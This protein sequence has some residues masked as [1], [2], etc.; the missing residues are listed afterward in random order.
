M[1]SAGI[2]CAG[3]ICGLIV[4]YGWAAV[5]P[6]TEHKGVDP[7]LLAN[8]PAASVSAQVGLEGYQL[9]LRRITIS[10]GGQ[11]ARHSHAKS[12]GV[13]YI[14]SGSWVEGRPGRETHYSAG[15][16]FAEDIN[17][18]HWFY[19]RGDEPAAAIVCDIKPV[20]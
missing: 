10:P 3:L 5:A 9:L 6:P 19:N 12:P 1:K 17:T 13:V 2:A 16:A 18:V 7:H 20:S 8:V 11:I 14:E 15:D 4:S